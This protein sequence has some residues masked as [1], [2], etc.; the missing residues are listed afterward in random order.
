MRIAIFLMMLLAS[1]AI[2][3]G[4]CS[5]RS[6]CPADRTCATYLPGGLCVGD[7]CSSE[8]VSIVTQWLGPQAVLCVARCTDE[9]CRSG[10]VCDRARSAC[11]PRCDRMPEGYCNGYYCQS[12]GLCGG[13]CLDD[14][15]CASTHRCV[16]GRCEARR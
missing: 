16:E 14:R 7:R 12:S 5:Q 15:Y 10:W 11:V 13:F 1:C 8:E 9:T 3:P 2:E 4:A 6:D